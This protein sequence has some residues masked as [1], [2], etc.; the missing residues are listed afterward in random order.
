VFS[1]FRHLDL[2]DG[3]HLVDKLIEGQR[4]FSKKWKKWELP[5]IHPSMTKYR[6]I[7]RSY[8]PAWKES[9]QEHDLIQRYYNRPSFDVRYV[10]WTI[11]RE[12]VNSFLLKVIG[13]QHV[14]P[15]GKAKE[16]LDKTKSPGILFRH[17]YKIFG[18]SCTKGDV[19]DQIEPE[20]VDILSRIDEGLLPMSVFS[21]WVKVELLPRDKVIEKHK[22]RLFMAADIFHVWVSHTLFHAQNISLYESCWPYSVSAIGHSKFSG[23][24]PTVRLSMKNV[25]RKYGYVLTCSI[26]GVRHDASC[27]KEE[28][29]NVAYFRYNLLKNKRKFMNRVKFVYRNI[30]ETSMV[31]ESGDV[32]NV[33]GGN[34]SG[35]GNTTSD[36]FII[37]FVRLIYALTVMNRQDVIQHMMGRFPEIMILGDDILCWCHLLDEDDYLE[38]SDI[39]KED[40]GVVWEL[41]FGDENNWEFCSHRPTEESGYLLAGVSPER[42]ISSIYQTQ[43][44]KMNLERLLGELYEAVP[45]SSL[46]ND[47]YEVGESIFKEAG[48][49]L[50]PAEEIVQHWYGNQCI[51]VPRH[52]TNPEKFIC[53]IFSKN[54]LKMSQ[55]SRREGQTINQLQQKLHVLE[56]KQ[57]KDHQ[58]LQRVP[59]SSS[60]AKTFARHVCDYVAMLTDPSHAMTLRYPGAPFSVESAACVSIIDYVPY[61]NTDA[62]IVDWPLG[63]FEMMTFAD[64]LQPEMYLDTIDGSTGFVASAATIRSSN[65]LDYFGCFDFVNQG[66]KEFLY[67]GDFDVVMPF[68]TVRDEVDQFP[69]L[70]GPSD[71][72]VFEQGFWYT[73]VIAGTSS[74]MNFNIQNTSGVAGTVEMMQVQYDGTILATTGA[75]A[76]SANGTATSLLTLASSAKARYSWKLKLHISTLLCAQIRQIWGMYKHDHLIWEVEPLPIIETLRRDAEQVRFNGMTSLTTYK[77]SQLTSGGQISSVAYRGGR[78]PLH[79]RLSDYSAIAEH[80]DSYSGSSV[81]GSFGYYKPIDY[82]GTEFEVIGNGTKYQRPSILTAGIYTGDGAGNIGNGQVFRKRN[83]YVIEFTSKSQIYEVDYAPTNPMQVLCAAHVLNGEPQVMENSIHWKDIKNLAKKASRKA[84]ALGK[85]AWD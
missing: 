84:V 70:I 1:G 33:Q 61:V 82:R 58:A 42:I 56:E 74:Y 71:S 32:L 12:K 68:R 19:L 3:A 51:G 26:D 57:K 9:G 40:L 49:H 50:P 30:C 6:S 65:E 62:N 27:H 38:I 8:I 52:V 55:K 24:Y 67:D 36:N 48:R 45:H 10:A 54:K 4:D 31:T 39:L 5:F 66:Y 16:Y 15:F 13:T 14:E 80:P 60:S 63:S 41:N 83:E 85:F 77:G 2:L 25:K 44:P 22:A 64:A 78:P 28:F 76:L 81:N 69:T 75:V 59:V 11:A 72:E 17:F 7:R 46:F 18:G 73:P 37:Q 47:L 21:A 53:S 23:Y 79:A 20:F 29:E 35:Q 34:K 43:K